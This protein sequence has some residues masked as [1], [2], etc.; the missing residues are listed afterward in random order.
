MPKEHQQLSQQEFEKRFKLIIAL[1]VGL[2]VIL[3]IAGAIIVLSLFSSAPPTDSETLG[4]LKNSENIFAPDPYTKEDL[5]KEYESREEYPEEEKLRFRDRVNTYIN[6]GQFEA[7]QTYLIGLR[8][9]YKQGIMEDN[10]GEENIE[11]V[12]DSMISDLQTT[13]VLETS[14]YPTELLACYANPEILAAT[15][16]Y[17]PI[18]CKYQ[19]FLDWDSLFMPAVSQ[20]EAIQLT[21]VTPANAAEILSK[22]NEQKSDNYWDIKIYEMTLYGYSFRFTCVM[23][24]TGYYQPYTLKSVDGYGRDVALTNDEITSMMDTIDY[25]MTIDDIVILE[26]FTSE[27]K[28]SIQ[29]QYSDRISPIDNYFLNEKGY[30]DDDWEVGLGWVD[31]ERML[32][33]IEQPAA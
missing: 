7:L 26:P 30:R 22:I 28:T 17:T 12:I 10:Q 8:D 20:T 6:A 14:A 4:G 24:K 29:A 16:A 33:I 3:V 5:E 25:R 32:G 18:M 13:L 1:V 11:Y 23:A 19:A 27:S 2:F 21:D 15:I 31:W 9:Q